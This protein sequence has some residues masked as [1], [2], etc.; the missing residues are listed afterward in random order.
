MIFKGMNHKTQ[1]SKSHDEGKRSSTMKLIDFTLYTLAL[2][3]S[4]V[5]IF[6]LSFFVKDRKGL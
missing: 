3:T 5:L 4:L 1:F 2:F 6:Q